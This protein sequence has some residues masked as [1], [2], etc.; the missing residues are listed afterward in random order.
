MNRRCTD[1]PAALDALYR[2]I[3]QIASEMGGT[4]YPIVVSQ[5]IPG[6][7]A[8]TPCSHDVPALHV[9]MS[10]DFQ[11]DIAPAH[12]LR[13]LNVLAV[14]ATRNHDESQQEDWIFRLRPDGWQR[15]RDHLSDLDIRASL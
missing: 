11:V 3:T 10:A 7:M 1:K 5:P 4:A 12:P 14:R 6:A 8:G 9:K 13:I 2:S 15:G